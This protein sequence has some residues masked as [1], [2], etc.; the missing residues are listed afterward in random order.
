MQFGY[1]TD[2]DLAHTIDMVVG[3]KDPEQAVGRGWSAAETP[4]HAWGVIMV[5]GGELT[6]LV[7]YYRAAVGDGTCSCPKKIYQ[8]WCPFMFFTTPSFDALK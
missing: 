3:V 7:H 4:S 6:F 5:G 8:F 2:Q 1:P